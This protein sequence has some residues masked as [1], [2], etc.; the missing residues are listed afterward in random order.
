MDRELL[1]RTIEHLRGKMKDK[2]IMLDSLIDENFK[3]VQEQ[4]RLKDE[5]AERDAV[6][7]TLQARLQYELETTSR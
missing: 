3:L 5:M 6:I 7:M 2:S 4:A 1:E